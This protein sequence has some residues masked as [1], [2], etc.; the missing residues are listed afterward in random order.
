MARN[1]VGKGLEQ[2]LRSIREEDPPRPSIRL[3]SQ[4]KA[5]SQTAAYRETD[6][7]ALAKSL[8]GDLDWVVMKAL[9][10]DRKRRYGSPEHF[11]RDIEN[12]LSGQPVDARS[13]TLAYRASKY[14]R[15]N[16]IPILVALVLLASLLAGVAA[17][18]WQTNLRWQLIRKFR[19]ETKIQATIL[20]LQGNFD[21][22]KEKVELAGELGADAMW[23]KTRE[24]HIE[25]QR[26]EYEQ[27]RAKL[28]VVIQTVPK[29]VEAHA[30]SVIAGYYSG[31]EHR[32]YME[33]GRLADLPI[34]N[35]EDLLFRGFA[36]TWANPHRA[37][38]DLRA[39]VKERPNVPTGHLFLGRAL[40]LLA[41][42][43]TDLVQ[44][45]DLAKEAREELLVARTLLPKS[46]VA[47][48]EF[49]HA[50]IVLAN[51]CKQRGA[52]FDFEYESVAISTRAAVD[53][54][55]TL[56]DAANLE[57]ARFYFFSQLGSE[58][59]EE[60]ELFRPNKTEVSEADTVLMVRQIWHRLRNDQVDRAHDIYKKMASTEFYKDDSLVP[61]MIGIWNATSKSELA[62][63]QARFQAKVADR[64]KDGPFAHHDWS[65]A[66]LLAM[67]NV[68]NERAIRLNQ[69][70]FDIDLDA[71]KDYRELVEYLL[72]NEKD[73]E[74]HLR[75]VTSN[76]ILA[77]HYFI[78]AVD[79]L[80][81]D[82][83]S[84]AKEYFQKVIDTDHYHYFVYWWSVAFLEKLESDKEENW[85]P[86]L[87]QVSPNR[88]GSDH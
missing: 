3:S 88:P 54:S 62:K 21:G 50:G 28:D 15:R 35:P 52:D 20:T 30:L 46:S 87:K 27:A 57:Q 16:Q 12:Y 64:D 65:V 2:I 19:D 45:Y 26:G 5:A 74:K 55:R 43:T 39:Y 68:A 18:L 7:G 51:A 49:I 59:E 44:T 73:P 72:G 80:A 53:E 34:S 77:E 37:V 85:L 76:N 48:A 58:K 33:I 6:E 86:W 14:V 41:A 70:T 13:P 79:Q 38:Q 8:R 10:K 78:L 29:S 42:D 83:R 24:A 4:G 17:T 84:K 32:Y 9:E 40:R 47:A 67:P 22:A 36:Q 61:A 81:H 63:L 23:T 25:I 31:H 56:N 69:I 71:A 60:A 75:D 82:D 11:A 66:K 1:C